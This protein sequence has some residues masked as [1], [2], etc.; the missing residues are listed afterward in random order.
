MWTAGGRGVVAGGLLILSEGHEF[1]P[2][3][4][5]GAKPLALNLTD[6]TIAWST[7]A[8]DVNGAKAISDGILTT[9][10]AYD[11]QIYGYGMG[12]SAITV[13]HPLSA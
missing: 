9:L 7:Q 6:G 11:N 1:A 4:F 3:L 8:F 5:H 12:P 13:T 2:P 10:N